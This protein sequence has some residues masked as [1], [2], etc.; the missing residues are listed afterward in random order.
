MELSLLSAIEQ[1][2]DKEV[3]NIMKNALEKFLTILGLEYKYHSISNNESCID[4][5]VEDSPE[6][7]VK[8]VAETSHKDTSLF[9][10][11]SDG[12]VY[13][14]ILSTCVEH[15]ERCRQYEQANQ[16]LETLLSQSTYCVGSRSRWWERL[17]LNL[18]QHLKKYNEV[19]TLLCLLLLILP[20]SSNM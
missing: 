19:S 16:L 20:C 8:I 5:T 10:R 2:H 15:L 12:S 3:E 9:R 7:D 6:K 18:D 4:L 14:R 1:K 11:Y 17:A 13:A